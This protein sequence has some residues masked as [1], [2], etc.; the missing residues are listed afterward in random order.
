METSQKILA[1]LRRK[2]STGSALA[3]QLGLSRQA[4]NLHLQRLSRE[5][6]VHREG[7]TR[8]ALFQ[9][10]SSRLRPPRQTFDRSY[11]LRGLEEDRAFQEVRGWLGLER[12]IRANVLQVIAYTFTEMLNNAIEHSQSRRC[13]VQAELTPYEFSFTITDHGV[14]V[15]AS[16]QRKLQLTNEGDAVMELLKGK[17]T[18]R[19]ERHTGEG[20]FFT[21]RVADVFR[22]R[23]HR[24]EVV[25][26]N[27]RDDQVVVACR[28]VKGTQAVFGIRRNSRRELERVFRQYAPEEFDY[29][30][31]RT[32]VRV[33]LRSRSLVSR[34]EAR[35]MVAGLEKFREIILD[36]RGVQSLGQAFADEVF[37]VFAKQHPGTQIRIQGL[38]PELELMVR[39]VRSIDNAGT[40]SLTTS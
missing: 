29:R 28:P 22:L 11:V 1:L 15:F 3:R 32:Q 12:R 13:L 39:H 17:T 2:P 36:F 27:L 31:E 8:G 38:S 18:T 9:M 16:I 5:G 34:S 37:R 7:R 4:I 24:T 25:F 35:R 30:F 6:Q 40:V 19:P 26:D 20:I 10:A 23:S 33:G 14:G 21:A